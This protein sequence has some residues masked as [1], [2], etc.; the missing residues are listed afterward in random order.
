[1]N[2]P[3]PRTTGLLLAATLALAACGGPVT[4]SSDTGSSSSTGSSSA[5]SSYSG[6]AASQTGSE[7]G[8]AASGAESASP[9]PAVDVVDVAT[10]ETVALAGLLPADKPVLVWMWAPH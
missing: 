8:A 3:T 10:G 5:T 7:P 4:S 6:A 9:L 1:M 2:V